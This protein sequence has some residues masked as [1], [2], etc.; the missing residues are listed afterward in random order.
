MN[1]LVDGWVGGWVE[2]LM[3]GWM[4]SGIRNIWTTRRTNVGIGVNE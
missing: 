3:G 4:D 2:G 1:G